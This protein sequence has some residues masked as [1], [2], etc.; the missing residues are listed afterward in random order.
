MMRHWPLIL[1]LLFGGIAVMSGYLARATPP[2]GLIADEAIHDFGQLTQGEFVSHAFKLRNTCGEPI[3][4][5]NVIKSCG[6][7]EVRPSKSELASSEGMEVETEWKI[8]ASRGNSHVSIIVIYSLPD[9]NVFQTSLVL[10]ADVLPDIRYEPVQLQFDFQH[11]TQAIHFSPG[12]L[13][14]FVL[15]DVYCTHRAFRTRLLPTGTDLEVTLLP[16]FARD[17]LAQAYLVVQTT[18]IHEPWCRIPLEV[19]GSQQH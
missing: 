13:A 7:S 1:I 12:Q 11:T 17:G 8:G 4:I 2:Q 14:S 18:S 5:K 10:T 15:S 16:E 19:Q 6:C 3:Q 9:G